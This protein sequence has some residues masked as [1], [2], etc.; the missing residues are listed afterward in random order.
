MSE[1][2][3]AGSA[4]SSAALWL[5]VRLFP[6]VRAHLLSVLCVYTVQQYRGHWWGGL[7][8]TM[9]CPMNA[10]GQSIAPVSVGRIEVKARQS[11]AHTHSLSTRQTKQS[12]KSDHIA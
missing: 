10:S 4:F 9:N 3:A 1:P 6:C 8:E 12:V 2:F 5:C 11:D 7:D